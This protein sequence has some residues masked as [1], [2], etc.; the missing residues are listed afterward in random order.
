MLYLFCSHSWDHS[1]HREGLHGLIHPHW[2]K[3]VDWQDLA[4]PEKHP[5][6]V[7]GDRQLQW[8]L[9]IRI[10]ACDVAIAFAG[11]YSTLSHWIEFE[12]ETAHRQGKPII[13]V[14]PRGQE[15]LSSTVIDHATK[16]VG[17]NGQSIR[18]AVLECLPY[19]RWAQLEATLRRSEQRAFLE[20]VLRGD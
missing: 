12:V 9:A 7:R 11:V 16:V 14:K 18:N 1:F 13:A 3:N 17:W 5:L 20:E 6:H 8:E 15:R 2:W 10:A 4:V 19:Q